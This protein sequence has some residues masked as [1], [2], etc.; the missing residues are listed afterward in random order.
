MTKQQILGIFL[1][2][3]IMESCV[4]TTKKD[5]LAAYKQRRNLAQSG[6]PAGKK[7]RSSKNPIFV[8][9]KHDSRAL[10]YDVRL[11][12]D[13]VLVSWAVPKGPSLNPAIK[14]L[15]VRT[16]DHPLA[17]AN[18][19]GVIPEGEYGAGTVMVWDKGTFENIKKID[20]KPISLEQ[21]LKRGTVEVFLHGEKL[22]GGFALI[23]TGGEK[24]DK[25]LLIKMRDQFARARK[26]PVNTQTKSVKTGRTMFQIKK[27][28]K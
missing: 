15:A 19:E 20:G 22:E 25:W 27:G 2:G 16:D 4:M 8:I 26:N 11:E 21:S 14:R 18:F 3:I 12:I 17:Y 13:G 28:D 10:H 6:E 24:S 1:S 5:S 9:Q 7:E 23:R